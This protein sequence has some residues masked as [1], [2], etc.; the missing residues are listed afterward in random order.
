MDYKKKYSLIIVII[1]FV[2]SISAQSKKDI[3]NYK[4]ASETATITVTE[5]GKENTYK[6]SYTVYD[7]NGSI[8]EQTEFNKDGSVKNKESNKFDTNKN[9]IETIEY[10]DKDKT[11]SKTTFLYDKND[12]K[13]LEIEY[14]SK[15][16][17][18]KQSAYL[19]NN[20]GFK[21]EK[22]TVDGN[23][24]LVAVKKYIYANH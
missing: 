19:Y 21:T 18:V 20:K 10:N 1:L 3:R 22:R 17:I 2:S 5:N 13:V 9:K 4:I 16:K 14:D 6:D 7:K 8:I 24:K 11:I 15:G 23:K 12:R